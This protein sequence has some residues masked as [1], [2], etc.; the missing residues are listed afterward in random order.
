MPFVGVS[1]AATIRLNL[2][3]AVG[4]LHPEAA[5]NAAYVQMFRAGYAELVW[6]LQIFEGR[7]RP[8]LPSTAYEDYVIRFVN[9]VRTELQS[10]GYSTAVAVMLSILK[11][12]EVEFVPNDRNGFPIS[13]PGFDRDTLA[14]P[15]VFIEEDTPTANGLRPVFDLVWQSAGLPRSLNFDEAGEWAPLRT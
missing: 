13:G 12:G 6:V 14:F 8:T 7:N 3:G 2:D 11:A 15:D 1:S 10:L 4:A 9:S 5:R